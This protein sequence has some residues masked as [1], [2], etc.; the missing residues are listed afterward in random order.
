M[1]NEY[2]GFRRQAEKGRSEYTKGDKLTFCERL[3][4]QN[5]ACQLHWWYIGMHLIRGPREEAIE[6]LRGEIACGL[7]WKY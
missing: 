3:L 1:E 7:R 2:V 5:L 4:L 6:T